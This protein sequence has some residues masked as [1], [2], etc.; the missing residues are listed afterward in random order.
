MG[1]FAI[2]TIILAVSVITVMA[3]VGVRKYM[4]ANASV[5]SPKVSPV[6]ASESRNKRTEP[7]EQA[8]EKKT[9][10][11]PEVKTNSVQVELPKP[12]TAVT[13]AALKISA[14]LGQ[15]ASFSSPLQEKPFSGKLY[16]L[17][18]ISQ[19]PVDAIGYWYIEESEVPAAMI[20]EII[21]RDEIK[22]LQLF[23]LLQN[24]TKTYIDLT[25]NQTNAYGDGS[26]YI[27]HAKKP[28]EAFLTVRIRNRIYGFAYV[29]Y[30]HPEIKKLIG[31]LAQ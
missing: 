24:K 10:F 18:D 13:A 30:F 27:N 6:I 17:L 22:A 29:K 11:E 28:N 3:D 20:T 1:K 26:F 21:L 25:L 14:Q 2:F 16:D 19:N 12:T 15:Q 5:I 9:P 8:D 31:L 7:S 4:D 23:S